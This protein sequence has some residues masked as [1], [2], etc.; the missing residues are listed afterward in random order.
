MYV[1]DW[2]KYGSKVYTGT[3][4]S[5][6]TD[7]VEESI[8]PGIAVPF[9]LNAQRLSPMDHPAAVIKQDGTAGTTLLE[10][11][12]ARIMNKNFVVH[13]NLA[14]LCFFWEDLH[15]EQQNAW[16]DL[17]ERQHLRVQDQ[18]DSGGIIHD[19]FTE[20]ENVVSIPA[21]RNVRWLK[22]LASLATPIAR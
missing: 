9:T 6:R 21:E 14:P 20:L 4:H 13:T 22:E 18:S 16:R 17:G 12:P 2:K 1:Q 8:F 11:V 19:A 10:I 7:R 15:T 3:G 5:T